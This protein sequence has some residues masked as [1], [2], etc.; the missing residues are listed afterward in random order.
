MHERVHAYLREIESTSSPH[1]HRQYKR[2]L[3]DLADWHGAQHPPPALTAG[4]L[5]RFVDQR[6]ARTGAQRCAALRGF[7]A[8]LPEFTGDPE[9]LRPPRAPGVALSDLD[10]TDIDAVLDAVGCGAA[11]ER[12]LVRVLLQCGLRADE[13]VALT[14]PNVGGR[15]LRVGEGA[16]ARRVPLPT[17]AAEAMSELALERAERT[18]EGP[19]GHVFGDAR[20]GPVTTRALHGIVARVGKRADVQGLNPRA[21]RRACLNRHRRARRSPEEIATLLGY[22]NALVV[23]RALGELAAELMPCSGCAGLPDL[24]AK[25]LH[26]GLCHGT[27]VITLVPEGYVSRVRAPVALGR[28]FGRARELRQIALADG[29]RREWVD[30][31]TRAAAVIERAEADARDQIGEA[32]STSDGLA[33]HDDLVPRLRAVAT[34]TRKLADVFARRGWLPDKWARELALAGCAVDLVAAHVEAG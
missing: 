10:E 18:P 22:Q 7:L 34:E 4:S 21:L 19:E 28:L 6:S 3:T 1:T 8:W 33:D 25:H 17:L 23:R 27:G 16:R 12:A 26:C 11:R 5:Q 30:Q 14:W 32:A 15:W 24:R 20:G 29:L 13:A 31:L 2:V 9:R